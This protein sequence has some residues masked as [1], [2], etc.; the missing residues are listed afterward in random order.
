MPVRPFSMKMTA[1]GLAV[2]LFLYLGFYALYY[3]IFLTGRGREE[4]LSD[5]GVRE[6]TF[7][8]FIFAVLCISVALMLTGIFG[9]LKAVIKNAAA[10]CFAGGKIEEETEFKFLLA[11]PALIA[12]FRLIFLIPDFYFNN[13]AQAS[14]EIAGE[15]RSAAVI[16]F[17]GS[18][19]ASGLI[20][21]AVRS[22]LRK[23][24]KISAVFLLG[25]TGLFLIA[26]AVRM[27]LSV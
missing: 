4:F 8:K 26:S 3:R 6:L 25:A 9:V 1:A 5:L 7:N 23:T 24:V 18:A 17:C 16:Y 10:I 19:A 27:L 11:V 20:A 13:I 21:A 12:G 14:K 22:K 15:V 2:F